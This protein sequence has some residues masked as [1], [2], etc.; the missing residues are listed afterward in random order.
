MYAAGTKV[1]KEEAKVLKEALAQ[2]NHMDVLP[3]AHKFS[4]PDVVSMSCENTVGLTGRIL[5]ENISVEDRDFA[6]GTVLT[7]EDTAYLNGK[8]E[9]VAVYGGIMAKPVVLTPENCDAVMSYGER[10][11]KLGRLTLEDGS[12]LTKEDGSFFVSR[13]IPDGDVYDLV[14]SESK[15]IFDRVNAG[16]QLTVWLVGSA[17]QRIKITNEEGN[18]VDAICIDPITMK[19]TIIISDMYAQY[20]Y[21]LNMTDGIGEVDDIDQLGNRRIRTVGELIQNQF[22]IGLS[23]MERVVKERMSIS[24]SSTLSPKGLTNIRPLTAAI[25]EFFASSQLSQFMDQ[26]NPLA[27]LTNKRRISA[28]GPG[29]LTRER[30]GFEVRDVHST[31]YGRICPIETPEGPNI[32]LINNLTTYAR[33][34]E[35]GFIQ[36]PYRLLGPDYTV[37]EDV[38][39]LSADEDMK[40]VIA[41]AHDVKKSN[42]STYLRSRS[43]LSQPLVFL[44]WKMTMLPV[45]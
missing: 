7:A 35:Y 21:L 23:R 1:R 45:P 22:R 24:D 28:L 12:D 32:G 41:Q 44:S 3:F 33:V 10:L 30:A 19:K 17:V 5:A 9:S 14:A 18:T 36:T 2:G 43:Y 34:N 37:T 13:Y 26:Q 38:V 39:Y 6:M 29:G 42:W 20:S 16:G 8:V 4:H 11:F 40:Y 25:K 31:H 27:E 15:E